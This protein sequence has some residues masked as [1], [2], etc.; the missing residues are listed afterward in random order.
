M[1]RVFVDYFW[2]IDIC[3]LKKF[4]CILKQSLYVFIEL[5]RDCLINDLKSGRGIQI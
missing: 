5:K 4:I 3:K 2:F 1:C